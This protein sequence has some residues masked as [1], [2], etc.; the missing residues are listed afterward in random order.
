MDVTIEKQ[1]DTTIIRPVG[2]LDFAASGGFQDNLASALSG[3]SPP[4][5]RLVIDASALEYVSSAGL[6]AFLVGARSAKAG[7]IR[8]AVCCLTPSVKEVFQV[9]GFDRIIPVVGTLAEAMSA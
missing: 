7:G 6:R 8:I 5:A 4:P 3:A 2:R 1:G 9:S